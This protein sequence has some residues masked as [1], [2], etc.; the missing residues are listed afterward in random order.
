MYTN[1]GSNRGHG[2]YHLEVWPRTDAGNSSVEKTKTK[3]NNP[4]H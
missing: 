1:C 4:N 3:D 2:C